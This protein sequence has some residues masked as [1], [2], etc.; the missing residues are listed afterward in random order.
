MGILEFLITVNGAAQ[1]LASDGTFLGVL[2][3]DRNDPN[4]ISNMY[5]AYGSFW[6]MYSVRNSGSMY[7]GGGGIYSPFNPVGINPPVVVYQNQP[8]LVVTKNLAVLNN[9]P[10]VDPE[11]L[12][13]LYAQLGNSKI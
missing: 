4:S 13:G 1:L 11:L 2:S 7:G 9:L 6:G 10:V 8:V 12:L 5:G 3:S